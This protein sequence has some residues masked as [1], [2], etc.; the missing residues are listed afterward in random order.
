MGFSYGDKVPGS[1]FG[2][3]DSALICQ[4]KGE[5]DLWLQ[6]GVAST[7][8]YDS[9]DQD[10]GRAQGNFARVSAYRQWIQR[11]VDDDESSIV[12]PKDAL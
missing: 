8:L 12:A 2:D 9:L 10:C 4:V 11:I 7:L 5:P 3:S 1:C 6:F